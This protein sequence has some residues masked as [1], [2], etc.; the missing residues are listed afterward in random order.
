MVAT[1]LLSRSLFIYRYGRVSNPVHARG[2]TLADSDPH[3][4]PTSDK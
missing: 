3:N 2:A 4:S 1:R